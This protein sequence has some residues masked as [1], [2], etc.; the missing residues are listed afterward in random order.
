MKIRGS[1][2]DTVAEGTVLVIL[3]ILQ[4]HSTRATEKGKV[5]YMPGAKIIIAWKEWVRLIIF[6]CFFLD[7]IL[8][9]LGCPGTHSVDPAGL[10]LGD[11]PTSASQILGLKVFAIIARQEC[12][13]LEKM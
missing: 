4:G 13:F 12:I 7:R 5:E 6:F 3:Y 10:Q 9:S 1:S 8:C 2:Y 11:P